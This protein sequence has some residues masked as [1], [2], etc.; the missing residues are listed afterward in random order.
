MSYGA[1]TVQVH[2]KLRL[3]KRR[4]SNNWYARITL[5]NGKR[6]VKSTGTEDLEQAKEV[7]LEMYYD[8]QARLKNQLPAT[9]RKFKHVAAFAIERMENDSAAGT[10]K[11]AYKDYIS[12]LNRWL[13]PY[14]EKTDVAK[15]DVAKLA[16]FD[17]WREQQ[18]GKKPAQST[19]NNHNAALNR[20]LD[21]AELHGWIVKS[22]RPTL[23][24]KGVQTKS[25]GSFTRA[26]YK[27]I[28]TALR[29]W[30]KKT[31]NKQAAATRETLRNY[32]LCLANTGIRHGTEALS[33]EWRNIEWYE[34]DGERYLAVSVN[35][36]TK[37]R[38]TIARDRVAEFLFRQSKLNP[39]LD[40]N[41]LDDLIAAKSTEKVFT[42]R[43]GKVTNVFNLNRAFNP[44]L[45]KLGL[46]QGA[47]GR[48][49]TL[50][51]WRHFY[52]TQDLERGVS[53]HALGR[54][55]GTSTDMLDRHYS[56]ASPLIN[57][58]LH[59]GRTKRK[60]AK[61]AKSHPKTTS[62]ADLAF[63][64]LAD[65]KLTAAELLAALGVGNDSY[66]ATEGI[67]VRA[68]QAK[69]AEQIDGDTLL[70]ILNGQ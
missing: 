26:E 11:Q 12:A 64:M 67:K 18:M 28:Y 65:G 4:G 55:M 31:T 38:T 44:L 40:Y 15:I 53:T 37:E 50:Y 25:R 21:E 66:K 8:V 20:V 39:R 34:K 41:T 70:K 22:M 2:K 56:K 7:A 35:G 16:K 51:S 9:T 68:L 45:D 42:T 14:F 5:Q 13:I 60:I 17:A 29:T 52:A 10:G 48:D 57:A 33:L 32:V 3:D 27:E 46:K 47:D 49:R 58:E 19:I 43:L 63:D 6:Q 61:S 69:N 24:N 36:K 1:K 30:H 59:S 54:Q 62:A 23:L